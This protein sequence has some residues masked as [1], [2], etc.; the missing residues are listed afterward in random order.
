[1]FCQDRVQQRIVEQIIEIPSMSSVEKIVEVPKIPVAGAGHQGSE[2]HASRREQQ[3]T[4]RERSRSSRK[5]LQ[6]HL[7][8]TQNF[9]IVV[10][11][12]STQSK[13]GSDQIQYMNREVDIPVVLQR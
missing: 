11:S 8:T 5:R 12:P 10:Q 4:C 9:Q 1:M 13:N 6:R 3:N 2:N 7:P